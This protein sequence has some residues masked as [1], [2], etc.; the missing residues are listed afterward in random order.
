M[1]AGSP[2]L[3]NFVSFILKKEPEGRPTADVL[4]KHP[5]IEKYG[6]META[7]ELYEG[8]SFSHY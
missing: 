2:D 7:E 5:F 3:K 1:K 8:G 4:L 6:E